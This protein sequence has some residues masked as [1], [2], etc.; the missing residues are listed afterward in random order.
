M[1]ENPAIPNILN[2]PERTQKLKVVR[3]EQAAQKKAKELKKKIVK[4]T[5]GS[6]K[7]VMILI[8][9]SQIFHGWN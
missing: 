7:K 5:G 1:N 8:Q 3:E 4:K 2:D 6:K 9:M